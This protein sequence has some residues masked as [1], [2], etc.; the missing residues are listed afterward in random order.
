MLC[1]LSSFVHKYVPG[2]QSQYHYPVFESWE[3]PPPPLQLSHC[4][5]HTHKQWASC[6]LVDRS[7]DY[8]AVHAVVQIS[9]MIVAVDSAG[10]S[11]HCSFWGADCSSSYGG[12]TP[13]WQIRRM[14]WVYD[15]A[16][17]VAAL[18]NVPHFYSF[19][20][21][22]CVFAVRSRQHGGNWDSACCG[23]VLQ[24]VMLLSLWT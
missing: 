23:R 1:I 18:V 10:G 5:H 9:T 14:R 4:S 17:L 2:A 22:Y 6:H 8:T 19:S 24:R 12:D 13:I 20:G 15:V 16:G 11:G 21:C 7:T 3:P